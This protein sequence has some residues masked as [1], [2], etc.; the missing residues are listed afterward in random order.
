MLT[1]FIGWA[2]G[3]LYAALLTFTLNW[4]GDSGHSSPRDAQRSDGRKRNT[5]FAQHGCTIG[6][7]RGFTLSLSDLIS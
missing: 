3:G 6:Y 4:Q 2:Q 7:T 1:M 5:H